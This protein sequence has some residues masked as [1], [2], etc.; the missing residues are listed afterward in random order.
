MASSTVT[1]H[2]H[3]E[4]TLDDFST[5]FSGLGALLSAIRRELEI[6]AGV[7]WQVDGLEYGS[8][9][10]TFLGLSEDVAAIHRI[11][12]RYLDLGRTLKSEGRIDDAA[13]ARACGQ[14]LSVLN[15]HVPALDFETSDDEVEITSAS[16]SPLHDPTPDPPVAYG[17]VLGRIQ[18]V[19]NR[20][21]L[22]FTLYDLTFDRAVSCYVREGGED[23]LRDNWGKVALVKG[24]I[25][26]ERVTGRPK[27]IRRIDSIE[28]RAV[29]VRGEWRQA[30]GALDA[31]GPREPAEVTIRRIRD[32]G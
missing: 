20:G 21:S 25:K 26:R 27:T 4:P 14:I 7:T 23:M 24:W 1:L 16:A 2:L 3:G 31:Y 18:T 13:S 9:G 19:S 11:S 15:G 5:A 30:I 8:A 32:A 6:T 29:G 17:G 12:G 22:H 28:P 10:G